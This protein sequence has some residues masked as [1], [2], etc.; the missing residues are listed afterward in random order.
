MFVL[1]SSAPPLS[2]F[3][4]VNLTRR[5]SHGPARAGGRQV[6]LALDIIGETCTP[7]LDYPG[8]LNSTLLVGCSGRL[9]CDRKHVDS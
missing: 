6:R 9:F 8:K 1:T 3:Y 2:R 7:Y 4:I 5:G